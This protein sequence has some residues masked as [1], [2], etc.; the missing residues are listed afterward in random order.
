MHI[1][2]EK[3]KEFILDSGLISK[4]TS[5]RQKEGVKRG[6]ST[7]DILVNKG[8]LHEDDLRR[9]HAHILGIP[10]VSLKNKKL[11]SEYFQ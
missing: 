2:E 4:K 3:L 5:L 11:I 9:I 8:L 6:I 1:E 10:F 7:G